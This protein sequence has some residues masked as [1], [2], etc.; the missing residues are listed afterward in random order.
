MRHLSLDATTAPLSCEHQGR[1]VLL[2]LAFALNELAESTWLWTRRRAALIAEPF[3]SLAASPAGAVRFPGRCV[4]VM[5]TVA[6]SQS[7]D[8]R[9]A[10]SRQ[11]ADKH[12]WIGKLDGSDRKL[13]A[14]IESDVR[15]PRTKQAE[16]S[17]AFCRWWQRSPRRQ[18]RSAARRSGR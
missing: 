12:G 5:S 2:A 3:V 18:L 6:E 10:R 9:T 17:E 11:A 16:T 8:G 13:S 1:G 15:P 7:L 4:W 14:S